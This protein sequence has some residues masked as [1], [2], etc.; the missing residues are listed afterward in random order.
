M[1][2]DDSTSRVQIEREHVVSSRRS[3]SND[4][5]QTVLALMKSALLTG[6]DAPSE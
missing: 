5:A 3:P 6:G 4:I 2:I 1:C